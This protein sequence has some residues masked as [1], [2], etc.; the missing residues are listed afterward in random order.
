M[1]VGVDVV[2]VGGVGVGRQVWIR[3][4]GRS[5]I[6]GN[7][8]CSPAVSPVAG[9]VGSVRRGNANLRTPVVA[10]A[11]AR[12]MITI[13]IRRLMLKRSWGEGGGI[14]NQGGN[15]NRKVGALALAVPVVGRGQFQ[16]GQ[17]QGEGWLFVV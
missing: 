12:R 8:K 6:I 11:D 2:G 15:G 4:R 13:K 10:A 5:L 16:R 3:N 14:V 7:P 1:V 9:T 17:T